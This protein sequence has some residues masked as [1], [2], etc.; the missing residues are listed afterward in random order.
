MTRHRFINTYV[1]AISLDDVERELLA[2]IERGQKKHVV[3]INALKICEIEKNHAVAEAINKAEYI[4]ADGVPV[5]WASRL[6]GRPLR[7]RVNGTDLFERL[8]ASAEKYGKRV[9]LLGATQTNLDT[10]VAKLGERFPALHIA[11]S[12]NGYYTDADDLNVLR[13]INESQAELLFVG[14]SSPKKE[15]WVYK[16]KHELRPAVIQGVG[17]SFDVVAGIIPRAPRWMQRSGLE[18]LDRVAR[19]PRRM[20]MRYLT[21]NTQF[22]FLLAKTF[23]REI[24]LKRTSTT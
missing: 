14:I 4:L 3:F 7:G 18:W 19:E 20:F 8:L 23:V 10:L 11:G 12:R 17:G 2:A 9:F 1:D 6:F 15:L 16:Y 5:L 21:N 24:I 22:L 13:E